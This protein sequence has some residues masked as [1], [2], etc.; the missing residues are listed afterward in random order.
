MISVSAML[1]YYVDGIRISVKGRNLCVVK[2]GSIEARMRPGDMIRHNHTTLVFVAG[3][4]RVVKTVDNSI[5][6]LYWTDKDGNERQCTATLHAFTSKPNASVTCIAAA[7]NM[8]NGSVDIKRSRAG[9]VDIEGWNDAWD[10]WFADVKV[11]SKIGVF[12]KVRGDVL[13]WWWKVA[14]Y[15]QDLRTRQADPN[16]DLVGPD[17]NEGLSEYYCKGWY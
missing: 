8:K 2:A 15:N 11:T 7:M 12:I 16:D 5:A 17:D 1:A 10:G 6:P 13:D 9:Q 3:G 4:F 14:S